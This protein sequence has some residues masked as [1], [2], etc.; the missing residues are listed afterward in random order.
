LRLARWAIGFGQNSPYFA[1]DF[2]QAFVI[3]DCLRHL[4]GLLFEK[5]DTGGLAFDAEDEPPDFS[6]A[7]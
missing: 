4:C 7:R 3:G 2:L 6:D 1:H 5:I